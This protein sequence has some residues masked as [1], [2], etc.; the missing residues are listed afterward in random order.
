MS[1]S[2]LFA[3]GR[4]PKTVPERSVLSPGCCQFD[5]SGDESVLVEHQPFLTLK[6]NQLVLKADLLD[7]V[8]DVDVED[9]E[10]VE[11]VGIPLTKRSTAANE[12][13]QIHLMVDSA[14]QLDDF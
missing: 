8:V 13:N 5:P 4:I 12:S 10:D 11:D 14:I 7:S 6:S 3:D 2:Y 9:V 1:L